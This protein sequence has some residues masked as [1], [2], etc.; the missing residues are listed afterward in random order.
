MSSLL[1]KLVLFLLRNIKLK[2][3][4]KTAIVQTFL[5]KQSLPIYDIITYEDGQ[6]VINKRVIE[7]EARIVLRESAKAVIDNQARRIIQEQVTFEAMKEALHKGTSPEQILFGKAVIWLQ[8][9]QDFFLKRL[10]GEE[11][12]IQTEI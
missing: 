9:Y 11:D 4:D 2:T 3:E 1:T 5:Q 6:L 12:A 8:Q 7:G 10:A